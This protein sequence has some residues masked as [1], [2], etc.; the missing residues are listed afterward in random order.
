[1]LGHCEFGSEVGEWVSFGA[2]RK[3]IRMAN[4][5]EDEKKAQEKP[6]GDGF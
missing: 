2:I 4:D 6:K 5:E 1:M 3:R